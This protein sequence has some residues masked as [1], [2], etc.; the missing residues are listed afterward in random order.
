MVVLTDDLT[1]RRTHRI[2]LA[3]ATVAA[4]VLSWPFW[5][6]GRITRSFD[7]VAYSAPNLRFTFEEWGAGRIPL[8]NDQIFG[9]VSHLGN[10]QTGALYPL[11][12]FFAG[13]AVD[14]AIDLMIAVHLVLLVVTMARLVQRLG[15]RAPAGFTAALVV[16]AGGATMVKTIQFEQFLVLAWAPLLLM[17]A[18]A[19]IVSDRPWRAAAGLATAGSLAVLAGHPQITYLLT[20]LLGAWTLGWLLSTRS[21]KRLRHL[22]TAGVLMVVTCALQL[23][24]T[25]HATSVSAMGDY[26]RLSDLLGA[27]RS[28]LPHRLWDVLFGTVRDIDP[29][30]FAGGFESVGFVGIT[31][32]VLAVVGATVLIANR[33]RRWIGIGLVGSA[34]VATFLALGSRTI[35]YRAAW[36][37]IP[38]FD[39][40][41]V[42]ARWLDV[43]TICVALLA[44]WGV[45]ALRTATA[46]TRVA[47]PLR[48][49]IA[50]VMISLVTGRAE[51]SSGRRTAAWWVVIG[52]LA[53]AAVAIALRRSERRRFA[54]WVLVGLAVFELG[55]GWSRGSILRASYESSIESYATDTTE[56]LSE[57]PGFTI[58]YTDD[59][60]GDHSLLVPGLRPNANALNDIRSLDGYDGGIQVTRRWLSIIVRDRDDIDFELPLRN[61]LALP[62]DNAEMA[63]LNVRWVLMALDRD[64]LA[65]VP[66][67]DG[68]IVTDERFAV[69]ENGSWRSEATLWPATVTEPD[70]DAAAL[71]LRTDLASLSA[72]A[73]VEPDGPSLSC[74]SDCTAEAV[75]LQRINVR[76]LRVATDTAAPTLLSVGSQYDSGWQVTI[77]GRSTTA[78]PVDGFFLGVPVPA[79]AH[80][81]RFVYR[82][83]WLT[84]GIVLTVIGGLGIVGLLVWERR[85][86]RRRV[87]RDAVHHG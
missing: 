33:S 37:L 35:V 64:A 69:W 46:G 28:V 85:Y 45:D 56:F 29:A 8:W 44:A 36:H 7:N 20:C 14:R 50:I 30:G 87:D 2:E 51:V 11:R 40:P 53:V 21:W 58:A 68:T 54:V 63:R 74:S 78:V 38:G 15:L 26:R 41:R 79:G 62:L 27:D 59:A 9:G 80:D 31:A 43:T 61:H 82:P 57:T 19:V 42:P 17:A 1:P 13:F 71:R 86:H 3:A 77:D 55:A 75:E 16:G 12:F 24:A 25:V 83:G 6:P 5:R 65:H 76:E 22:A 18:H 81:V 32:C 48:V 60:Y 39:L 67:F 52:L 70:A 73:V 47:R 34:F 10:I 84:P 72:T 23:L 4:L 49:A 66:E